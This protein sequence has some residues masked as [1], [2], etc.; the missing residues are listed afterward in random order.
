MLTGFSVGLI[1]QVRFFGAYS[2]DST[3][4]VP[5]S[6]QVEGRYP[7][8]VVGPACRVVARGAAAALVLLDTRCLVVQ[9]AP[10]PAVEVQDV[11]VDAAEPVGGRA[12]GPA[13]VPHDVLGHAPPVEVGPVVQEHTHGP[14]RPQARGVR[15]EQLGPPGGVGVPVEAGLSVGR[16]VTARSNVPRWGRTSNTSPR[17]KVTPWSAKYG[18]IRFTTLS[19]R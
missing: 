14:E 7:E 10:G 17:Y 2:T 16:S 18:S 15:G 9:V 5:V 1:V 11:L 4:R 8:C 3:S 13:F 19:R 6:T 12:G